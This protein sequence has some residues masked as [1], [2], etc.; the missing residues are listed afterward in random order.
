MIPLFLII[1]LLSVILIALTV[2]RDTYHSPLI[3]ASLGALRM[4]TVAVTFVL[5]IGLLASEDTVSPKVV[6][7]VDGDIKNAHLL[8]DRLLS[9]FLSATSSGYNA[10]ILVVNDRPWNADYFGASILKP[11]I[12]ILSS[13]SSGI[14]RAKMELRSAP[15]SYLAV[16]A[17]PHRIQELE[18][19][20]EEINVL[21]LPIPS[22][23][24]RHIISI[25]GEREILVDTDQIL[26]VDL[27][28]S[29][30]GISCEFWVN[31]AMNTSRSLDAG[32]KKKTLDLSL[33][34]SVS[35]PGLHS[36]EVLIRDTDGEIMDRWRSII[37]ARP[38]PKVH[39]LLPPGLDPPLPRLLEKDG[40]ILH[41]RGMETLL[42]ENNSPLAGVGSGDLLILD[43]P[44]RGYLTGQVTQLVADAIRRGA[45][46]LIIPGANFHNDSL[47]GSFE[48]LLPIRPGLPDDD[49]LERSLA[50]V[51]LVDTSMSMHFGKKLDMAKVALLNL[52]GAM[53]DEDALGILG[54]DFNP[55][56]V[57]ALS[58]R[59]DLEDLKDLVGRMDAFGPGI[60][61]YSSLLAAYE[62]L[63]ITGAD[64]KHVLVLADT[65][66]IDEYEIVELGD[67][68]DLLD[69]FRKEGITVSII[70]FGDSSDEHIP[71]LNRFTQESGG[72]FYLSTR[73]E[74]IPGF[75]TEDLDQI[76]N[77]LVIRRLQKV[78]FSRDQFPSIEKMPDLNGQVLVTDKPGSRRLAW[79]ERGYSLL[80]VW[81]IGNGISAVFAADGGS[82]LAPLWVNEKATTLW[83]KILAKILPSNP[84]ADL[85]YQRTSDGL[86]VTM[87]DRNTKDISIRGLLYGLEKGPEEFT[88]VKRA[89]D[90]YSAVI[91]GPL[92][93]SYQIEVPSAHDLES[94]MRSVLEFTIPGQS[95]LPRTNLDIELPVV[96]R[97]TSIFNSLL[98]NIVMKLLIIAV[99][100]MLVVDEIFRFP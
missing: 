53:R 41:R 49:R 10:V 62:D 23:A 93:G 2:R 22:D 35:N 9:S 7:L 79:S 17:P 6:L 26:R 86:R 75:F 71:F 51:A 30:T 97:D 4:G 96:Q 37:D 74:D 13:W 21:W 91:R 88:L 5:F 31:N 58:D 40:I 33:P 56:W 38:R 76:S 81:H 89:P 68:W 82:D 78:Q 18:D 69:T 39:Y 54:T 73:A 72:F 60:K 42:R 24:R 11:S 67:V 28:P 95:D 12:K 8:E 43:S 50:L 52:A 77:S 27:D 83:S 36:L 92:A 47:S 84:T 29:T 99:V 61:L 98:D 45:S 3:A 48:A 90:E 46:L 32:Q 66:D 94:G 100:G 20:F 15:E 44:P 63:V 1:V 14:L 87:R 34:W 70:G 55:Y 19:S 64:I 59:K 65:A 85:F 25:R 57:H 16:L 80:T